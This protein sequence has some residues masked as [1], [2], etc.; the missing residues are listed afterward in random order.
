MTLPAAGV[1]DYDVCRVVLVQPAGSVICH[2]RSRLLKGRQRD[3]MCMADV[4]PD[5]TTDVC[6]AAGMLLDTADDLVSSGV[7][8]WWI[9]LPSGP[10]MP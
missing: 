2:M 4:K 5:D 3:G 8:T 1:T 9:I 6:M 10:Q 7:P